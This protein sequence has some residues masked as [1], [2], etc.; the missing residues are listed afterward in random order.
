MEGWASKGQVG[1][2]EAVLLLGIRLSTLSF[3]RSLG[4]GGLASY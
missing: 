2:D 1:R 3:L 4:G